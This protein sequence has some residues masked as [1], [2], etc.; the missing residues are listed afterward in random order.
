MAI[1]TILVPLSG[2]AA[3]AGTIETACRLAQRFGAHLEALHVRAD[4][5]EALPLLGT[6]LSASVTSELIDAALRESDKNAATAKAA[7]DAAIARHALPLRIRPRGAGQ[8]A[9]GEPSA[10][11][12]EETGP[13]S[14]IVARRTRLNDLVILGQS[15]RVVDQPGTD[16]PEETIIGGGRPVLLAP[17]RP[18]APVGEVVAIAWNASPQAARAVA[19]ALPF[20][21]RSREV[22]ILIAG[23]GGGE[24]DSAD[25][26]LATY[27]AWHGITGMT[28]RVRP[29]DGVGIGELLLTAAR[30]HGA[31]L[32]VMGG[33][34]RA[35]WREM[36]F[37]GA[38][39]QIIGTSRL[40]IL[41]SH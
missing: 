27:L 13:A 36:I 40:P 11:W 23:K 1:R 17:V 41:L 5:R 7:F 35:P 4:P 6:D 33:Y 20:L 25:A 18:V 9:A 16:V 34:G 24:E 22:H 15:G 32:L 14:S 28:D 31:D 8:A 12:H 29:I 38:T 39:R 10:E 21:R 19:A 26:E 3:S 30:D 37:G 2:G